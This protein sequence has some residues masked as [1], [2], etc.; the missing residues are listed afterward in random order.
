MKVILVDDEPAALMVLSSLL[1]KYE[2]IE[3]LGSYTCPMDALEASKK[4]RPDVVFLDIEMGKVNGLEAAE[5]FSGQG[6]QEIVFITAYSQYAVEA[7][8]VNAL[9][10]LL[11]PIQERRLHRT[12]QRLKTKF[13][14]DMLLGV[15]DNETQDSLRNGL[16][17]SS[18]GNFEV[19]NLKGENIYWRTQKTKELFAYLWIH[20]G[21]YINRSMIMEVI[22]P[23]KNLSSAT[24]LL[25]TTIYQLRKALESLGFSDGI[26]Y[27]NESYMLQLPIESDVEDLN[28]IIGLN[29]YSH[30]EIGAILEIYRGDF[31]EQ[32][33]YSWAI[34]IQ[35]SLRD[36]V[37]AI[38]EAYAFLQLD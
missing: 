11:K 10:Y 28:S 38:L 31:L 17:I 24:A 6:R 13:K 5:L 20:N 12:I 8:E 7:F 9:D 29:S 18:L 1:S 30:K 21:T 36:A 14:D 23:D 32:E 22:F 16:I 2:D 3:I 35:E 33:G 27:T 15:E 25:H 19:S 37:Y 4:I 34:G 26:V